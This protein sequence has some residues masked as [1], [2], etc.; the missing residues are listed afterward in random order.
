M[1]S[2][3]K[4]WLHGDSVKQLSTI[5]H[6]NTNYGF[7]IAGRCYLDGALYSKLGGITISIVSSTR[8]FYEPAN[9]LLTV[10]R[11]G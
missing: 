1:I 2:K 7:G 5:G 10:S 11:V 8:Y 9:N 4:L 3:T 6:A